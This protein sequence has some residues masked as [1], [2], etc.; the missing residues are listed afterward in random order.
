MSTIVPQIKLSE[1]GPSVSR[2]IYGTWHMTGVDQNNE[3]TLSAPENILSRIKACLAAGITTFDLSDLYG[4]YQFEALFGEA[5]KLE[6][7]IK[8]QIQIITKTDIV[9]PCE[10]IPKCRI[11]HYNTS[12]EYILQQVNRSLEMLG[13]KHIDLLLLHRQDMLMD[14]DE[15]A[16]AFKLLHS[17]GKVLHFG[18]S[19]F[20]IQHF[21]LLQ[22]RLP[23]PLVSNQFEFSPYEMSALTDDRLDY[24]QRKRIATMAYSPLGSGR[25]FSKNPD[26][27]TR[28]LRA[29]LEQTAADLG[30][31]V[32]IDQVCY[33][34]IMMHPAKI[35]PVIGTTSL[36]RI[37]TAAKSV[38]LVL[39]RQQWTE[40]WSASTGTQV[41]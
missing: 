1:N 31:D 9:K 34:W 18:G 6:P 2:I 3:H 30:P 13:V 32:T 25:L 11:K 33:A 36:D 16:E 21:K 29:I 17:E 37:L 20:T 14:A 39:D 5:L 40:I 15:V 19:N 27:Q 10:A 24:F 12:R 22:S 4:F 38:R 26:E 23:F 35:C 8:D 7:E 28:R 41:P